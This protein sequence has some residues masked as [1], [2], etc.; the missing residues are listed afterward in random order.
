MTCLILA[1]CNTSKKVI[2]EKQIKDSIVYVDRVRIDTIREV[3][4]INQGFDTEINF[5]CDTTALN[6]S[7]KSGGVQYKVIKEKG[8]IKFIIKKDSSLCV[9]RYQSI[10]KSKDSLRKVINESIKTKKIVRTPFFADFW[11]IAF[12]ILLFLWIFGITPRFIFKLF[13]L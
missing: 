6:Q 2:Q 7:Y 5:K 13:V 9:D 11:R 3:K 10:L 12:F 8:Q 1:S 4:T